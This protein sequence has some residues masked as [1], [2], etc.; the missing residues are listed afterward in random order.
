MQRRQLPGQPT[1]M[2]NLLVVLAVTAS[3]VLPG[4]AWGETTVALEQQDAQH[5]VSGTLAK[6]DVQGGKGMQW[7]FRKE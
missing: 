2:V 1:L 3:A 6:L 4:L 7:L 5:E